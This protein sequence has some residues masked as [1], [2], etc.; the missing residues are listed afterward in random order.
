MKRVLRWA[1]GILFGVAV[2]GVADDYRHSYNDRKYIKEIK[3]DLDN[4]YNG[5]VDWYYNND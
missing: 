5:A 3:A 2:V 4:Q 1:T